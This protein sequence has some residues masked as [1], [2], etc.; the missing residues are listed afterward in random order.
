MRECEVAL[1]RAA[2]ACGLTVLLLSCWSCASR[3]AST[4]DNPGPPSGA[5]PADT[6]KD[7]SMGKAEPRPVPK[8]DEEW[9][10]ALTPEQYRVL[11][12][13]GT[14]R[15]FTGQYYDHH[16]KGTYRCAGCGALLFSSDAK[17][18]SGCGWPSFTAPADKAAVA[19]QRD[20][21]HGMAR[22]EVLCSRCRGHLGHVF[23]DGPAP[24]GL[25]YCINS[26]A[27]SFQP[28][29]GQGGAKPGTEKA[30]FAAGCFWGVEAAFQKLPGVVATAVG[31]AGGHTQ[32]PTYEQVCTDKTGH[33]ETV[34]VEF[35]P[36]RI[37]YERLLDVFWG[38]HDPT[39]V[40]RQ[41]PDVGTQYR[42]AIFCVNEEQRRAAEASKAALAKSGRF[43]RPIATEITPAGT[44]Y[45]AEEYH[46]KYLQKRGEK[47]CH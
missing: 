17:Y 28:V 16:E 29:G 22:T 33:A 12:Q 1:Q 21:S 9:R 34:E 42:S 46:Q 2:A 35:D 3:S 41:G 25:R 20:E 39:A 15:A 30:C 10:G 11:R 23:N 14:E 45:R 36:A 13:K 8:T 18:D 47:I 40:N 27:L 32:N 43:A 6:G 7:Q 5:A 44:F 4:Q 31:Y 38:C 19:Q 37:S 24:T 26:A